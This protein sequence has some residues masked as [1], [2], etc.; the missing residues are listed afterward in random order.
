[1]FILGYLSCGFGNKIYMI[2]YYIHIF[3][4]IRKYQKLDKLYL[5][6]HTT[7]PEED[8]AEKKIFNIF[9]LLKNQKWLEWIYWD[10]YGELESKVKTKIINIEITDYEKI[11]LPLIF[12]GFVFSRKH[13]FQSSRF[14]DKL[15][16]FN[17]KFNKLNANYNFNDI[18][19]HIRLGDKIKY[20][21]DHTILRKKNIVTYSLFTP[22][23]YEDHLKNFDNNKIVYIFT[24]SPKIFEKFYADKIKHKYV[25]VDLN[26]VDSFNLMTKFKNIILSESTMSIFASY[27]NN[28]SKK[29][30]GHKYYVKSYTNRANYKITETIP[31]NSTNLT[32]KKYF[33]NENKKLLID[34]YKFSINS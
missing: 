11:E 29:I 20:I 16:Q 31:Y 30:F 23:Y 24:D 19:V 7:K 6:H 26:F 27:F 13:Y 22:E 34:I 12:K 5:V 1:M 2:T 21:Y 15:F 32:S 28:K 18:G 25:L 3:F 17:S 33:L 10:K 8:N 4:K 14:Y 9:Q